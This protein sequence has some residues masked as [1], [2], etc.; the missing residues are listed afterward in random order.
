MLQIMLGSQKQVKPH[1]FF[2]Y[3]TVSIKRY[4][5]HLYRLEHI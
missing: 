3:D 2:K 1:I 4:L 5:Y